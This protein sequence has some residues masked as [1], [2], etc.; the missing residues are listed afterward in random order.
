MD[1]AALC[2]K[3]INIRR[4]CVILTIIAV[5]VCPWN[6]VNAASTFILVLSGWSIFLSGM[7]GILITDYFLVRGCQLHVGDLYMSSSKSAYWYTAGFNWRAFF[8]WAMGL[9]PLLRKSTGPLLDL[10]TAMAA[11]FVRSVRGTATGNGWD[12]TYDISYL[13]GK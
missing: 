5:A 9:W 13:F 7:T 8:A 2:P 6:Y 4:G 12:H 11:G 10:L 3:W 1:M